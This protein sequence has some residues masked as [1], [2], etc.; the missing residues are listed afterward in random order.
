MTDLI[1]ILAVAS[2][3]IF[4]VVSMIRKRLK[5]NSGC[6]GCCTGC[7]GCSA[8]NLEKLIQ[9]AEKRREEEK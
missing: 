1:I 2:Y 5:G 6:T 4:L 9:D 8:C 7:S 3:C